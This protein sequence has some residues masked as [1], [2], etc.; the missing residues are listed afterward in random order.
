MK[1]RTV[2]CHACGC[3]VAPENYDWLRF[4]MGSGAEIYFCTLEHMKA[5]LIKKG[6]A[7]RLW[8][9]IRFWMLRNDNWPSIFY[10]YDD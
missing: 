9:P 2:R 10:E 1:T 8:K 4:R 5:S 6:T 7:A 3:H